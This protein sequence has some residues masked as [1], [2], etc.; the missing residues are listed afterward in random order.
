MTKDKFSSCFNNQFSLADLVNFGDYSNA[1]EIALYFR[2]LSVLAYSALF[3]KKG[4]VN[5]E[6][7]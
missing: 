4:P 5:T 1:G 3:N 7:Q 6:P 2:N